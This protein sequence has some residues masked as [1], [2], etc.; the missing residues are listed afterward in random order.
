MKRFLF[1][2]NVFVYATGREHPLRE[3]CRQILA[4]SARGELRGELSADLLQELAFQR[5][6]QTGDRAAA[7]LDA[8]R[9]AQSYVVHPLQ[10]ADVLRGLDL[11]ERSDQLVG[12]DTSFA[13]VALG[14]GIDVILSADRGFDEVPGLTRV[15][16]ADDEAV[17]AL[18]AG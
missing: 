11:F 14:R 1:D 12:R 9:V 10:V 8:R 15:D 17:G 5:H 6:R 4:R 7:C 18:A 16:P 13:A 3:P 2:T